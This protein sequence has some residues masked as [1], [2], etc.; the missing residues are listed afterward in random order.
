MEDASEE[1]DFEKA[2][3]MR[4]KIKSLNIMIVNI[5][6][7]WGYQMLIIVKDDWIIFKDFI[8]S[9]TIAAFSKSNSSLAF[10]I[11]DE[12]VCCIFLD[13]PLLKKCQPLIKLLT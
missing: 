8:L 10:S 5:L 3:I 9:L 1:L 6:I 13:R 12:S 11:C 2:A 4:D 7:Q